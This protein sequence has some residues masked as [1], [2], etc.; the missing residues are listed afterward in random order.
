YLA[1]L[2]RFGQSVDWVPLASIPAVFEAVNRGDVDYGLV[3]LEN[4]TDGRI[5]DTLDMFTRLPV[6]MCGEVP[7]RIH[8]HVLAKCSWSEITQVY[9]KTQA[10]SQCREWLSKHLSSVQVIPI[11]STSGAAQ[12]ASDKQGVAAIASREAGVHFGLDVLAESIQDNQANLTRFAVIGDEPPPRTGKDKTA[13]MFQVPHHPG[14]LADA[15]T[16]FKKNKLNLTW[17]ESF[18]EPGAGDGYLFFT[19]FKG[20]QTDAPV[21]RALES[22]EKKA[23]RLEVLGSYPTTEPVE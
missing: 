8:H 16:I 15:L 2:Q 22:L 19:E 7:L 14:A 4:S 18:P 20:F 3:P 11:S 5:V 10:L 21:K 13:L 23:I 12:L 17:I 6:R 9:S 1:A